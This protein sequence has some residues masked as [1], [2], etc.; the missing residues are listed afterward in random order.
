MFTFQKIYFL[1]AYV[2]VY[3]SAYE[4]LSVNTQG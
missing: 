3:V 1:Y 4:H 2:W